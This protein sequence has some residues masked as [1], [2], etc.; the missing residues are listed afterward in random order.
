MSH[1]KQFWIFD[2]HT[3]YELIL[4]Q[5]NMAFYVARFIELYLERST[6]QAYLKNI[7]ASTQVNQFKKNGGAKTIDIVQKLY[8]YSPISSIIINSSTIFN[9][10]IL[11]EGKLFS[12]DSSHY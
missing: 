12:K 3:S 6:G 9:Q 10:N 11:W 8:K 1:K 2:L 5:S 4:L 7:I